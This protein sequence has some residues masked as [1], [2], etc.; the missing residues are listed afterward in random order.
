[1][2]YI[3]E[4]CGKELATK[5][6]LNGHVQMMH[7]QLRQGDESQPGQELSEMVDS[8]QNII[9][10]VGKRVDDLATQLGNVSEKLDRIPSAGQGYRA[11]AMVDELSES[12]SRN[13]KLQQELNAA[14]EAQAK[15]ETELGMWHSGG[16]FLAFDAE[17]L[18]ADPRSKAKLEAYVQGEVEKAIDNLTEE[19]TREAMAKYKI[20]EGPDVIKIHI[21]D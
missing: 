12:R 5:R 8:L 21:P 6:G 3:C 16:R 15:A 1:M 11:S 2:S 4:I 9:D 13:D 20:F 7:P 14:R 19:Q 18:S 10:A 17:L